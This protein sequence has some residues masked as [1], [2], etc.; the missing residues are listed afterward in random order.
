[1]V[2]EETPIDPREELRVAEEELAEAR[3]AA[4]GLRRRIGER[5]DSPTDQE[6]VAALIT[7]AEEQEAFVAALEARRER[8]RQRLGEDARD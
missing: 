6:E 8:L 5:A 3:Q 2:A 4:T 7:A 1:M